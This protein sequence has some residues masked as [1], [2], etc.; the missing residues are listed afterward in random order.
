MRILLASILV[1]SLFLTSKPLLAQLDTRHYIPPMFARTDDATGAG[2]D[3]YLFISTPQV[4]SITVNVTDGAGTALPFSPVTVSRSAPFSVALSSGA[5]KGAGTKFLITA[6]QLASV[7][8]DEG[9]ILTGNKAF[10]ASIRVDEG[11][12]AA[13][14]TSKGT[15]GFGKEFR[16]GHVWN[17]GGAN[18][19]KSH[20]FSFMATEDNTLVTVSDF[21]TVDFEVQNEG[22]GSFNVTLDA[23]ES[24][25]LAAFA[26]NPSSDN[27]N[28]VNGTRISSD[29]SIVVNSGSWLAGSPGGT[30]QGRDI[31]LDQI[32]SIEQTGFEYILV[33]GEGTA[34][35]NVLAVAGVNGTNIFLNGSGTP[36]NPTPL[37]AGDYYRLT[38][39][40]YTA[41]QNMHLTSNQPVY[42][43]QGLN[44]VASTNERQLGLNFIPPIVCLGGTNVDISDIDQLGTAVIQIIA[45]T[46]AQ[47]AITDGGGTTDITASSLTVT[48][49]SNYVTYKVT[50][51]TGDI[52]V[53][54]PRPIRVAL[55]IAS[56]NIGAAGF[57][58]GFTTSPVIETPNGYNST[59]CIPDNLPVILDATGFDS[60]QWY[61][62]AVILP[63]ET[64]ASLSVNGPG[65]YTAKGTISGCVS[66]EQSFPL[67]ISL[68]PG[69]VGAS[70][71]PVSIT[72]VSGSLFDVVYDL[73]IENFSTTNPTPNLQVTDDLIDGLPS[74]ATASLQVPPTIQSGSFSAGGI[75]A[76]YNGSSDIAM[77]QT[78]ASTVDT[79]LAA[80]S[81]ITIRY[82][83]RVDMSLSLIH[84]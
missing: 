49:N 51:Y 40:D 77:L 60:Y 33:K 24:Y 61:R 58:S 38:S 82:T 75:S 4:S 17:E 67:T 83:V 25:V 55:T 50:G 10:F 66:S 11:A 15:S 52:T 3:I 80:S 62:D 9:L 70:L 41:N 74:G 65:V 44:G 1:L 68:C 16:T 28:N 31:G 29:K 19:L 21:G 56:G 32:A 48:G 18:N 64:G 71:N 37:N 76:T 12:Q 57:F 43:Y 2:E 81:S 30:Q 39:S 5:S 73:I 84:I 53:A 72:N 7:L 20:I 46:G 63:G 6:G 69:D 78:S 42:V 35:E 47:V 79:E 36:V 34:N 23:G 26:D 14:L 8:S 22:A 59:T 54:S 13:M 27:L 45:E